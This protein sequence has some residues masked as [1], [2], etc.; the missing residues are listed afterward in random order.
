LGR[1]GTVG[2]VIGSTDDPW[3]SAILLGIQDELDANDLNLVRAS[4]GGLIDVGWTKV[5]GWIR[6]DRTAGQD[7]AA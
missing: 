7:Q 4:C 1:R 6:D 5:E 2:V 3:T